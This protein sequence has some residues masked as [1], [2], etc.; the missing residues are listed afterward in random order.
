M[1]VFW[2]CFPLFNCLTFKKHGSTIKPNIN[3]CSFTFYF[4]WSTSLG[5]LI[6][7]WSLRTYLKRSFC[8]SSSGAW[9]TEHF[10]VLFF[11]KDTCFGTLSWM[12]KTF[13]IIPL[14][15]LFL[16]FANHVYGKVITNDILWIKIYSFES[17]SALKIQSYKIFAILFVVI[18]IKVT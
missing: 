5:K 16:Y 18:L 10:S 14:L 15:C 8:F 6:F 7:S 2:F 17:S 11:M 4:I 9:I 12:L 1:K 13:L 3:M